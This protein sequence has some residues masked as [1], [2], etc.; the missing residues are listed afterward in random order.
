ML[1]PGHDYGGESATLARTRE[2]NYALRIESLE[3]WMESMG[4]STGSGQAPSTGSGQ[5]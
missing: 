2:D 3:A 5:Q 1:Y 4:P